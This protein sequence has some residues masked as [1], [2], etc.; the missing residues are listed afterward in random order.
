MS[1]LGSRNLP[2]VDVSIVIPAY[3]EESRIG[4]TLD[5][6]VRY[7]KKRGSDFEVI[8]VD[9]GSSDSTAEAARDRLISV[10]HQILRNLSNRGKGY[11]VRRGILASQG[12]IVLFADSDLS[13]PIEDFEK[14]EHALQNGFDVAIGSRALPTSDVQ[15]HQNALREL[16]GKT[17]NVIARLLSFRVIRDSQC[18]FKAFKAP[19]AKALFERQKLN[20]FCFDAEILFLAQKMGYPIK[21]IGVRWRN[22]PKSRVHIIFDPIKMFWDLFCIRWLHF[23]E[24]Y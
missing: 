20:G 2:T 11:S 24:K 15:I 8:V 7:F 3:N 12:S 6:I 4:L 18:G 23:G 19:A 5:E 10:P 9:D 1:P 14:L 16:M 21:E 17:F 13:T 22:S